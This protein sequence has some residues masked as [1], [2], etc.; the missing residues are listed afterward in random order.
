[1]VGVLAVI[2]ALKIKSILDILIYA[3]NFWSPV[4]LPPLLAA[5]FGVRTRPLVFICGSLAGF[6]GVWLWKYG[7]HAPGGIDGLVVGVLCNTAV[8]LMGWRISAKA[9]KK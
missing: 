3:Y 1:M 8:F 2:F 5:L 9:E 7:L 4:I 6:C